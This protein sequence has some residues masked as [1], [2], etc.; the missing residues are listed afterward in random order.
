M[1]IE[2]PLHAPTPAL[3][4]DQPDK[5]AEEGSTDAAAD[6]DTLAAAAALAAEDHAVAQELQ[7]TRALEQPERPRA[8]AGAGAGGKTLSALLSDRP[9]SE[10]LAEHLRPPGCEYIG[11]QRDRSTGEWYWQR[12]VKTKTMTSAQTYATLEEAAVAHD[13]FMLMKSG[14]KPQEA[15]ERGLNWDLGFTSE[16]RVGQLLHSTPPACAFKMVRRQL[17]GA[18]TRRNNKKKGSRTVGSAADLF[19]QMDASPGPGKRGLEDDEGNEDSL[20]RSKRRMEMEKD[21]AVDGSREDIF[22]AAFSGAAAVAPASNIAKQLQTHLAAPLNPT[23]ARAAG[24]SKEG[25]LQALLEQ[26]LRAQQAP[27]MYDPVQGLQA[28]HNLQAAMLGAA[29]VNPLLALQ[30]GGLNFSLPMMLVGANPALAAA[31]GGMPF[32]TNVNAAQNALGLGGALQLLQANPLMAGGLNPALF[33]QAQL[34]AQVQ[35]MEPYTPNSEGAANIGAPVD[36]AKAEIS[37]DLVM[38]LVNV[39]QQQQQQQA[40]L[41]LAIGVIPPSVTPDLDVAAAASGQTAEANA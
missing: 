7:H 13:A 2:A 18:E 15:R 19:A 24:A 37:G 38:G 8:G 9:I 34:Q 11:L 1:T 32:A 10:P 31:A 17:V 4:S 36:P 20:R 12:V 21:K 35:A 30:G 6:M 40:P 27:I 25:Q 16:P 22:E 26:I 14:L 3:I 41:G 29:N 28:L 23:P 5:P 33:A 39:Q